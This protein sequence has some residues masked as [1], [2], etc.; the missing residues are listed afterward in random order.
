MHP[1]GKQNDMQLNLRV[2]P[3]A[4]S[5]KACM[6]VGGFRKKIAAA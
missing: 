1:I 6:A 4:R 5:G 2:K 3:N